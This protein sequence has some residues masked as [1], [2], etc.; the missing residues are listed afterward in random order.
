MCVK[1]A[2]SYLSFLS[3]HCQCEGCQWHT[4]R[5][6][7]STYFNLQLNPNAE[8]E[9]DKPLTS[10]FSIIC[11]NV[12]DNVLVA[13]AA[14]RIFPSGGKLGVTWQLSESSN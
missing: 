12:S 9:I 14:P 8:S 2:V 7:E 11:W 13:V 3:R 5:S 6:K 1:Q 10:L 4:G